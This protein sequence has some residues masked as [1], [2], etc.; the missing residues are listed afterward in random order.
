MHTHTA[1]QPA[2]KPR[3]LNPLLA[4]TYAHP[5]KI[6]SQ[7][8]KADTTR[9]SP[10]KSKPR[11]ARFAVTSLNED[12]QSPT[13]CSAARALAW[14]R[15]TLQFLAAIQGTLPIS[16]RRRRRPVNHNIYI[17][18]HVMLNT[19]LKASKFETK[20]LQKYRLKGD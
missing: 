7:P 9:P 20:P 4:C 14:D 15:N 13:P 8:C 16:P 12:A 6:P 10:Q 3:A 19:T 18:R 11:A 17:S 5:E 1:A 2:L